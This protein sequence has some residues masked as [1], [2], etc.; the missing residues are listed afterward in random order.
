MEYDEC[1]SFFFSIRDDE[2]KKE[3]EKKKKRKIFSAKIG[4]KAC[5]NIQQ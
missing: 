5:S 2:K 1:N 3:E 4:V